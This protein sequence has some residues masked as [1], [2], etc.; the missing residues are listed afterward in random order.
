VQG[1]LV[2]EDEKIPFLKVSDLRRYDPAKMSFDVSD[3]RQ[4]GWRCRSRSYA[5]SL[6]GDTF[7]LTMRRKGAVFSIR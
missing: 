3:V 7:F 1:A 6:E 2:R 5:V 4:N